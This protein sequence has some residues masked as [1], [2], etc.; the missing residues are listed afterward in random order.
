MR[1]DNLTLTGTNRVL[2]QKEPHHLHHASY[3]WG[4]V[5]THHGGERDL[6]SKVMFFY[7]VTKFILFFIPGIYSWY[8]VCSGKFF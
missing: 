2:I 3:L 5:V 7:T 1:D 8:G 4:G 6:F